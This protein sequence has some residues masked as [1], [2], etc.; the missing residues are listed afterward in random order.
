[1]SDRPVQAL[2][3]HWAV[4]D[5]GRPFVRFGET[6]FTYEQTRAESRALA[7][8]LR[9]LGIEAG[10]RIAIDLPNW[11]EFVVSAMAAANLGATIVP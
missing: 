10:D 2:L 3:D 7:A 8:A 11:P 6:V 5:P 4:E 9:H 1:M